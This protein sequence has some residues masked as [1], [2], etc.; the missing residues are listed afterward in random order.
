MADE[1]RT[2]SDEVEAGRMTD[3]EAADRHLVQAARTDVRKREQ[4]L[5]AA[6]GFATVAIAKQGLPVTMTM[7]VKMTEGG[8]VVGTTEDGNGEADGA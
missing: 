5:Q 3:I 6:I 1:F 8:E 7:D 2:I 4:H